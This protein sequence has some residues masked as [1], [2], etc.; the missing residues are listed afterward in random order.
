MRNVETICITSTYNYCAGSEVSYPKTVDA[1]VTI[2]EQIT[3]F[4][5]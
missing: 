5:Q 3:E 1:H 4:L 2:Y